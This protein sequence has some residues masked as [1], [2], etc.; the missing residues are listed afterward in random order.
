MAYFQSLEIRDRYLMPMSF[1]TAIRE[2]ERAKQYAP[3]ASNDN[4]L[5]SFSETGSHRAC[6]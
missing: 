6:N 4:N 1:G 3:L 2:N 5:N